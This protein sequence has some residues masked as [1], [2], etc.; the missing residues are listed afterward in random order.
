VKRF[1]SR[2]MRDGRIVNQPTAA[3]PGIL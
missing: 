3:E 1:S 2:L